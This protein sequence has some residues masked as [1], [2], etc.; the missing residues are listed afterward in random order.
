MAFD[1]VEFSEINNNAL[2][3]VE[4]VVT[5]AELQFQWF[6]SEDLAAEY[7]GRW[8][9]YQL[10]FAVNAELQVMH[11]SCGLSLNIS[12]SRFGYLYPLLARINERLWLGHFDLWHED[13]QPTW[14]H[15]VVFREGPVPNDQQISHIV[16]SAL[17]DC[18]RYFPAF[19]DV[20]NNGT[21]PDLAISGAITETMG[22]A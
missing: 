11:V 12:Q 22:E 18:E 20:L 1:T 13:G 8:G 21:D 10:W 19:R 9:N 7:Q 2:Q 6:S 16:G 15:A 5:A 3:V 14:R 17:D 4:R